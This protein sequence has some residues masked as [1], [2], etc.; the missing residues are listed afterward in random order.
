ML[1]IFFLVLG[2][3]GEV[4]TQHFVDRAVEA[5]FLAIRLRV[6]D[7]R[8]RVSDAK[9]AAC[10]LVQLSRELQTIVGKDFLR[11][12]ILED[13]VGRERSG[14]VKAGCAL[15]WDELCELCETV[16]HDEN[17]TITSLHLNADKNG[18]WWRHGLP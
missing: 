6:V 3:V 16:T 18:R 2:M 15:Q 11:C 9:D 14:Y 5:F 13:P 8:E 17:E 12:A 4:S 7:L 10:V 1:R